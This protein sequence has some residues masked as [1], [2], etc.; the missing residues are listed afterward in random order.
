MT[1]QLEINDV[2]KE[3]I[4]LLDYF[5]PSFTSKIPNNVI[6]K[7]QEMAKNSNKTVK[8]DNHKKLKEQEILDETKDLIALIYY[9]YIANEKQKEELTEIWNENEKLYQKELREI[10]NPDKLFKKETVKKENLAML[11][12]KKSFVEKC[13]E[14]IKNF[15]KNRKN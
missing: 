4:S 11:E 6:N 7:L 2:A 12:Y 14:I 3:T 8:I 10:Y 9:S 1:N 15:F 5:D 13:L